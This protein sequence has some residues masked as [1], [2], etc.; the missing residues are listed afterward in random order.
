ML[1]PEDLPQRALIA[2]ACQDDLV[3][4]EMVARQLHLAQHSAVVMLHPT[5]CHGGFLLDAEF[6]ARLV[7]NI[8]NMM[9]QPPATRG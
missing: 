6:Q 4:A 1:W 5:A 7:S 3:P 9:T 8:R 2:A